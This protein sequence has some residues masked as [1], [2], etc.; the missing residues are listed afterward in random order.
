MRY[1]YATRYAAHYGSR[2]VTIPDQVAADQRHYDGQTFPALTASGTR[3]RVRLRGELY[4]L[5]TSGTGD[6][7]V[8]APG[9]R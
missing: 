3:V 7:V 1:T 5:G 6:P 4:G 2:I 8:T 9:A